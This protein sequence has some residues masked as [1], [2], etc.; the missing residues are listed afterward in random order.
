MDQNAS[1][2][3]DFCKELF[4]TREDFNNTIQSFQKTLINTL[5]GALVFLILSLGGVWTAGVL[6]GK[7]SSVDLELILR[8]IDNIDKNNRETK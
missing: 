8:K 7:K 1:H 4:L 6:L 2:N 5:V 3:R